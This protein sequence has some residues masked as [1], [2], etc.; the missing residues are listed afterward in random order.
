MVH[1]ILDD[2]SRCL[3]TAAGARENDEAGNFVYYDNI[4]GKTFS[5][6]PFS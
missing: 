2:E 4:A 5:F 6:N 1:I 3:V